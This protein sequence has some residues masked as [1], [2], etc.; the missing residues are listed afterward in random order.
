MTRRIAW[1]ILISVWSMLLIAAITAYFS[2]RSI[3]VADLDS[4]L[5]SRAI[6]LPELVQPPGFDPARIPQYDWNDSYTINV[7]LTRKINE[8]DK[9]QLLSADFVTAKDGTER[10]LL[11]ISAR[12]HSKAANAV[13]VIVEYSGKTKHLQSLLRRTK[14]ALFGFIALA[15]GLSAVV[16]IIVSRIVLRPLKPTA[17]LIRGIDEQSLDQRIPTKDLPDEI[18]PVVVQLNQLLDR[19]DRAFA[20]QKRFVAS[21]S[22]ELRTPVAALATTLELAERRHRDHD[23]IHATITQS[24]SQVQVLRLL[25]ERLMEYVSNENLS[26]EQPQDV[27]VATLFHQCLDAAA[28]IGTTNGIQVARSGPRP[29]T[30]RVPPNRLRSVIMNLL[31][32]AVEYNRPGG[33]VDMTWMHDGEKLRVRVSDTGY[34]ISPEALPH[35][36]SAFY[37][38]DKSRQN[39]GGHLGLGLFIVQSHLKL[40]NGACRVDSKANEGASFEIEVPCPRIEAPVPA[41]EMVVSK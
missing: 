21:A 19:L 14:L 11:K 40:M 22:H 16:V 8:V 5:Y 15:S 25:V 4:L 30:C 20:S 29:L 36:F 13:P 18:V 32:N 9:P 38:G 12:S 27:D 31:V 2:V 3:L 7:D 1:A 6:S 10:R 33:S 17:A 39:R 34:G 24:L 28:A 37:R 26:D 41:A 23:G 35:V